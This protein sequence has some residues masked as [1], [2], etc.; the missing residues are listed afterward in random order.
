MITKESELHHSIGSPIDG[1]HPGPKTDRELSLYLKARQMALV[2]WLVGT[3]HCCTT[4]L[5]AHFTS[6]CILNSMPIP[7]P[8]LAH[9]MHAYQRCCSYI[10]ACPYIPAFSLGCFWG[11]LH[12]PIVQIYPPFSVSEAAAPPIGV[13]ACTADLYSKL[14]PNSYTHASTQQSIAQ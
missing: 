5:P 12:H 11:V 4:V 9:H 1:A 13:I 6:L 2:G 8:K 14:L 7:N 10:P 3:S